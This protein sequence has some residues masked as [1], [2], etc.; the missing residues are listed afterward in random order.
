MLVTIFN[1]PLTRPAPAD[2]SAGSGTPSPHRR[3]PREKTSVVILRV[4]DFFQ[5]EETAN[6]AH[7]ATTHGGCHPEKPKAT[8]DLHFLDFHDARRTADPSLS[9]RMTGWAVGSAS[10]WQVELEKSQAL[11]EAKD[12]GSWFL[13][14]SSRGELQRSFASRRMTGLRF[15]SAIKRRTLRVRRGIR[16]PRGLR[17]RLPHF[18]RPNLFGGD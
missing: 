4:C 13:G 16:Y 18:A 1:R 2:E 17:L 15:R 11:S 5:F 10:Q 3:G 9:L 14:S 12:P 8:K 7:R 6:A